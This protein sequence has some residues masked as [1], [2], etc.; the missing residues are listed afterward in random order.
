[1]GEEVKQEEWRN[2]YKKEKAAK[3]RR[4]NYPCECH[5]CLLACHATINKKKL[6]LSLNSVDFKNE[7][8]HLL[9]TSQP[10]C[11]RCNDFPT[12]TL[13]AVPPHTRRHRENKEESVLPRVR[14]KQRN[15]TPGG[16]HRWNT[17]ILDWLISAHTHTQVSLGVSGV[18]GSK[19]L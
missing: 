3:K 6:G 15:S 1:M 17:L 18:S 16:K 12:S 19:R 2:Y 11:C 4:V 8:I 14:T 13:A 5:Q 9:N 7:I 10:K